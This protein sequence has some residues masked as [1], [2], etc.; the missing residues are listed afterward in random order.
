MKI[1]TATLCSYLSR[2]CVTLLRDG[3]QI[4]MNTACRNG[5][6]TQKNWSDLQVMVVKIKPF[7]LHNLNKVDHNQGNDS[8]STAV[9]NKENPKVLNTLRTRKTLPYFHQ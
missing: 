8:G 5:E 9:N 6:T 2:A 1:E 7:G 3:E 4:N